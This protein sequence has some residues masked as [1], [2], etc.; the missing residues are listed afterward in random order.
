MDDNVW[1]E[2]LQSPYDGRPRQRRSPS[3]SRSAVVVGASIAVV[4]GGFVGWLLAPSSESEVAIDTTT[5]METTTT[6]VSI[7]DEPGFLP[8]YVALGD[9]AFAPV[10]QFT[11]GERTYIAVSEVVQS[12]TDRLETEPAT[13]GRYTAETSDDAAIGRRE[14]TAVAAPGIRLIEFE[15]VVEDGQISMFAGTT[16]V[17]ISSCDDCNPFLPDESDIVLGFDGFPLE[18]DDPSLSVDLGA[19][20]SIRFDRIVL[21]DEWGVVDWHAESDDGLMAQVDVFVYFL[22]TS[23]E[24]SDGSTSGPASLLPRTWLGP[25]F[26]QSQPPARPGMAYGGSIELAREG[27]HITSENPP[28][29]IA[30]RWS[31]T[32]TKPTDASA[33]LEPATLVVPDED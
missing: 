8:G 6:Q 23:I 12:G 13:I 15:S 26:G 11:V 32:W 14:M 21:T 28:T 4:L 3:S 7:S 9:T 18:V 17:S 5:T 20:E 31:V 10:V 1:D 25:R 22:D 16:P 30:I 24:N 29:G 2:L 27:P 33:S 19:G